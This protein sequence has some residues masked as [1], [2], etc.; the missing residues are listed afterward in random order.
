[1]QTVPVKCSCG[2][3]NQVTPVTTEKR[4]WPDFNPYRCGACLKVLVPTAPEWNGIVS[5]IADA[6]PVPDCWW[7][8][9]CTPAPQ[10]ADT[11]N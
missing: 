8:R 10:Y 6:L 7:T 11:F 4:A 3:V 2:E 9:C 1:M 5:L